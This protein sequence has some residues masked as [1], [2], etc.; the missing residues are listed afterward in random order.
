LTGV[1]DDLHRTIGEIQG[2]DE[3]ISEGKALVSKVVELKHDLEHDRPLKP[4]PVNDELFGKDIAYYNQKLEEQPAEHKSWMTGAWLFTECYMYR[5]LATFFAATKHWKNYDSFKRQKD[6]T[7]KASITAVGELCKRYKALNQQLESEVPDHALYVLFREF[8]D[9]SLWGN[10]TDL[11]LLTNISLEDIQALQ[12]ADIRKKNEK[13]IIANDLDKAWEAIN[14]KKGGRVDIVL[15]NAGF[16][17]FTDLIYGLF[18]LDSNLA[19]TVVFHPKDIPWFV[20]DVLPVD[21]ENIVQQVQD[22]NF[23]DKPVP[24]LDF[25]AQKL[26]SYYKNGRIQVHPSPFWTSPAPFWEIRE[27]G[28]AGGDAVQKDLANSKLVI[29]K[30]DLN[31]RKL[32]FDLA[33]PKTTPFVKAIQTAASNN[34]HILTLRTCKA[35]TCTGLPEGKEQELEKEWKELGND[36]PRSWVY[37]GKYA[38]VQYSNGKN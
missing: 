34:V 13:N 7:F 22:P 27:G 10:A 20:S 25:F 3:K 24:D 1:I 2:N 29:F 19:Q 14:V 31:H 23:F 35:D 8:T 6:D 17:L 28:E 15:D 18:I 12:G 37:Y 26:S 33:W 30:G 4:L 21:L 5:L 11:S 32:L 16:E 36:D 38:V 9:I